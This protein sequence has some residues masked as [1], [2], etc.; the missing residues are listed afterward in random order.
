MRG[1]TTWSLHILAGI[2][3]VVLLGLHMI[4]MHLNTI[5]G[6][7]NFDHTAA[8]T[9]WQNVI[10][11]GDSIFA[12]LFYIV[13]LG[14]ALYHGLYGLRTI[15]FELN[16]PTSLEKTITVLFVVAGIGLFVFGAVTAYQFIHVAGQALGV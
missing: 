13:F 5:L 8:A 16:I 15:I 9:A 4:T 7:F 11:R 3:L 10:H 1:T 6:W 12:A 2:A 14:I